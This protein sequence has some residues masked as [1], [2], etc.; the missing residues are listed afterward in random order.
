MIDEIVQSVGQKIRKIPYILEDKVANKIN[1]LLDG[2]IIEQVPGDESTAWVSPVVAI[3]KSNIR[4]CMDMRL[5]IMPS[6][7]HIH[8]CS[9]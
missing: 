4:F 8:R 5:Q 3:P 2:D 7:D 1:K 6:K 9:Q